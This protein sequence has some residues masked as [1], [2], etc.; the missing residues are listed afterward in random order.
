MAKV[1]RAIVPYDT[2][3]YFIL[4][5]WY[6][7]KVKIEPNGSSFATLLYQ[8]MNRIDRKMNRVKRTDC[9]V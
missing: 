3:E 4:K 5:T 7:F 6:Q 8:K 2:T 9:A 1:D